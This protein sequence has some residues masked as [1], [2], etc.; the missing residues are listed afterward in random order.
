MTPEIPIVCTL[1]D[2]ERQAR[3]AEIEAIGRDALLGAPAAGVLSFRN[4][5]RTRARLDAIVG[6]ESRCCS[7]LTFELRES[8]SELRLTISAPES[9][10]PVARELAEAFAASWCA[11]SY[12]DRVAACAPLRPRL[13]PC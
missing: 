13:P 9:A 10:A 6:A 5:P 1:S 4:D 11:A 12:A 3:L 8:D 2:A 7:F